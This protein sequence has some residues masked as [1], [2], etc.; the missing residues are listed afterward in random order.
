MRNRN[1]RKRNLDKCVSLLT[2][3]WLKW[4]NNNDLTRKK[5]LSTDDRVRAAKR[6]E[7]LQTYR[8]VLISEIDAIFESTI[9]R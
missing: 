2:L 7:M 3:V 8:R 4:V 6:C 5:S 1:K 9:R